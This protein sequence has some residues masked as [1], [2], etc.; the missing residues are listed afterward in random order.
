MPATLWS[1]D[2]RRLTAALEAL[3]ERVHPV[4]VIAFGSRTREQARPDSDLDLA[5]LFDGP[6]GRNA[7]GWAWETFADFELPVDLLNID[8]A[9]HEKARHWLNSVHQTIAEEGIV[10]YDAG[11]GVICSDAVATVARG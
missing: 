2:E 1:V 10:L 11:R 6:P 7:S 4:R 5:I 8:A 3:I 9:R